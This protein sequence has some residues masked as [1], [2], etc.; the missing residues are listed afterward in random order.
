MGVSAEPPLGRR[1]LDME[2]VAGVREE[3]DIREQ[4]FG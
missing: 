4:D 2:R 3:P 1:A